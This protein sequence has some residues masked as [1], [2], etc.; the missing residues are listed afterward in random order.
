ML[1]LYII[2]AFGKICW[3]TMKYARDKDIK[4][5]AECMAVSFIAY[6][7]IGLAEPVF[8]FRASAIVF[9]IIL[10]IMTILWRLNKN[11]DTL[12]CGSG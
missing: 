11:E 4:S 10:A 12:P 8:L 1:F 6:F 5:Y 3:K 7:T 9:Y 2:F